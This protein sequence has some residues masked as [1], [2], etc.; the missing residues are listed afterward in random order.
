[1]PTDDRTL[2]SEIQSSPLALGHEYFILS[3]RLL[4]QHRRSELP[5]V[6]L[7]SHSRSRI[8]L[9]PILVLCS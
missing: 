7:T 6:S 8:G 5:G 3:G 9:A 2:R 4:P 1:M